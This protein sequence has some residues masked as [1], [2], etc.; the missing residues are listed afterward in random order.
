M[1]KRFRASRRPGSGGKGWSYNTIIKCRD[2]S[3]M[4]EAHSS[5]SILFNIPIRRPEQSTGVLYLSGARNRDSYGA[6]GGQEEDDEVPRLSTRRERWKGV[7]L[8]HDH[9]DYLRK[10]QTF[11]PPVSIKSATLS[12][13]LIH[14]STKNQHT[15]HTLQNPASESPI[16]EIGEVHIPDRE[17]GKGD[18]EDGE[19]RG[20]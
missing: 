15:A 10:T 9:R 13:R 14:Y 8:Y 18:I 7:G 4:N 3:E 17:G 1:K 19:E 6:A 11:F 16:H 5:V 20:F 2:S 12:I